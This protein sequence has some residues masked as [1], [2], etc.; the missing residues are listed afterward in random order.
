MDAIE[1][2]VPA[3]LPAPE[4]KPRA[5][6]P[7]SA[8]AT[9]PRFRLPVAPSEMF[10]RLAL[11]QVRLKRTKDPILIHE[12]RTEID[13]IE[14]LRD[15]HF[16]DFSIWRQWLEELRRANEALLGLDALLRDCERAGLFGARFVELA[17]ASLQA[18]EAHGKTKTRIDQ[19]VAKLFPDDEPVLDAADVEPD[20]A[21]PE[22][23][24]W[25]SP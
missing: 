13:E 14:K 17:R 3:P 7:P 12:I 16:A 15:R 10:D 9:A 21:S 18:R 11:L 6:A 2:D 4:S 20:D 8:S 19:S 23:D 1:A 22:P 5:V 25:T 24:E